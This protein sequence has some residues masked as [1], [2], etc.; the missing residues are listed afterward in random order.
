MILFALLLGVLLPAGAQCSQEK[1]QHCQE[2]V[3]DST[4]ARKASTCQSAQ[5]RRLD[6]AKAQNCADGKQCADAKNCANA[7]HCADAKNCANAKQCA[8]AKNCA[9]AK[10]CDGKQNCTKGSKKPN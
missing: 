10:Q 6:C 4:H 1:A 7:K 5:A 3:C 2:T 8:D 9:N